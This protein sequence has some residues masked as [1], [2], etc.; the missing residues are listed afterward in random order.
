MNEGKASIIHARSGALSK[1]SEQ[2]SLITISNQASPREGPS[3]SNSPSAE[4]A[5]RLSQ[6]RVDF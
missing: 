6:M 1:G 4:L 3:S 2:M 5:S